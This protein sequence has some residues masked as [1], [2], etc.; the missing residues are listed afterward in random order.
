MND[1]FNDDLATV[2]TSTANQSQLKEGVKFDEGKLRFDLIPVIP[3]MEVARL[4]TIG[5]QKYQDRNW[6]KGI[7]WSRIA[8]ALQRHW[9]K[10]WGGELY[11]Q[12]D[13]QHHLSSV[14]WCALTLMEY[15]RTHP[16]YDDR[17]PL[18]YPLK[19]YQFIGGKLEP[20]SELSKSEENKGTDI[21]KE[22]S[23]EKSKS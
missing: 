19:D 18:N 4:Y 8:S 9:W 10:Y 15:E 6:E 3:L 11:D 13:G 21:K 20:R 5:A 14:I 12:E 17:T 16:E 7:K 1:D 2:Q 22:E 23:E